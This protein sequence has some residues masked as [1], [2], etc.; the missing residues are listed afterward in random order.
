MHPKVLLPLLTLAFLA[1]DVAFAK[2]KLKVLVY[3]SSFY[4]HMNFQ[5]RLADLLV[6]AGQE[7]VSKRLSDPALFVGEGF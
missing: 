6:E 5:G 7:V 3:S 1:A 2:R 4:S